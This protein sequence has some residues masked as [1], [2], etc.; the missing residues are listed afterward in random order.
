MDTSRCTHGPDVRRSLVTI[1]EKTTGKAVW[2][3]GVCL[4]PEEVFGR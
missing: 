2:V 4:E 3:F 1:R